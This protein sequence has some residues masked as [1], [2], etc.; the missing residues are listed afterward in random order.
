MDCFQ[1][2]RVLFIYSAKIKKH[3]GNTFYARGTWMK[4][5]CCPMRVCM[6]EKYV[7]MSEYV[8]R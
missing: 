3:L 5:H 7:K 4:I 2:Q 1:Y 8:A 6:F